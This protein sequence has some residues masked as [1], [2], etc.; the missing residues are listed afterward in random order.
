MWSEASASSCMMI[1]GDS[2]WVEVENSG[3]S[4]KGKTAIL[5][6][7][8]A[9]VVSVE[10]LVRCFECSCYFEGATHVNVCI[11][12]F[13]GQLLVHTLDGADRGRGSMIEWHIKVRGFGYAAFVVLILHLVRLA[14]QVVGSQPKSP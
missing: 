13:W 14:W 3:R 12:E 8:K 6:A 9:V 2:H 7:G 10:L 5:V 11:V 1:V 4:L